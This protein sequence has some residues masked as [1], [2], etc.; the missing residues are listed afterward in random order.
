MKKYRV[1]VD[2]VNSLG[3]WKLNAGDIVEGVPLFRRSTLI[4]LANGLI[5]QRKWLEESKEK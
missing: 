5:I 4:D 2:V 1:L 3:T